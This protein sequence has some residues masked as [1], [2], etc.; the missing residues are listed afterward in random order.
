[1]L[2]LGWG[3][4]VLAQGVAPLPARAVV[5]PTVAPAAVKLN[6][7]TKVRI[8]ADI[9]DPNVI[10]AGVNLLKVGAAGTNPTIVG[11]LKDDGTGGDEIAG[12]GRFSIELTVNEPATKTLVYRI[13]APFKGTL[14]RTVTA[15]LPLAVVANRPP[16]A[17]P[18]ANQVVRVG[19]A[20]LLDGRASYDLDGER[21]TFRW[22][23]LP[24]AGSAATLDSASYVQ[25]GFTPDVAGTYQVQLVVNDGQVDSAVQALT[26]TAVAGNAAP[27]AR[28]IA[29]VQPFGPGATASVPLSGLASADPEGSTLTYAW[30]L[31]AVPATSRNASVSPTGGPTPQL[32]AD[33]PGRYLIELT[34][35]DGT[36]PSV[37]TQAWVTLYT[38]NTPPTVS[39][40]LDQSA[41]PTGSAVN[42]QG[43][44]SDADGDSITTV[45][46]R[47]I[48]VPAGST[49][50]P[51]RRDRADA[52]LH[53][54]TG[55]ATTS[56]S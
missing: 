49:A 31:K 36:Q 2:L 22:T 20:V 27:T 9:G 51:R 50:S 28:L 6:V 52:G 21:L 3:G 55:P 32:L 53:A 38:P 8:Y 11:V 12:D 42:L 1:M 44:A 26:V 33:K 48:A 14:L 34:V 23:L 35:H 40:G 4:L 24:P 41:K 56:S 15:D 18:G 54:R 39:A 7:A 19:G 16:V 47:F 46:W 29:I 30:A 45:Q 37:P 17:V 10:A 25:P 13:S 5:N 43:A